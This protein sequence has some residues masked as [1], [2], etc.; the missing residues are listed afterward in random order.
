MEEIIRPFIEYFTTQ[1]Y[2]ENDIAVG[3]I[4]FSG[5]GFLYKFGLKW[6][7]LVWSRIV[8]ILTYN[9][10]IEQSDKIYT[11]FSRKIQEEY[12]HKLRNVEA[13]LVENVGTNDYDD[14]LDAK[15]NAKLRYNHLSDYF[16]LWYKG[17][18]IRIT[19]TREKLEHADSFANT[20]MGRFQLTGI[21][22]RKINQFLADSSQYETAKIE[23]LIKTFTPS[24]NN[25]E[26][27]YSPVGKTFEHL[28]FPEK[29]ELLEKLDKFQS[30][31]S[32]YKERGIEWYLGI[33]LYGKAGSGKSSI[34]KA[35][36]DYTSRD[37]Y[38]V[39]LATT[40]D[41]DF[42]SKF[43]KLGKNAILLLDD[44]DISLATRNKGVDKD[45][46]TTG[47]SLATLLGCLDGPTSRGDL[48]V[49]MTT[50]YKEKLDYALI[51]KG[52]I[53][54]DLE[55]SYPDDQNIRKYL[56]NFY[57]SDYQ[58]IIDPPELSPMVNYQAVCLNNETLEEALVELK[59]EDLI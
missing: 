48:I 22:K 34:A 32:W 19:K 5:F 11:L 12:S 25:W 4:I 2:L 18:I 57:K 30:L 37:L 17:T 20:Y 36:S 6:V 8:R 56:N 40:S 46:T 50:N 59:Q 49:I 7:S 14:E 28:F 23:G 10:T 27:R 24:Y 16:Y 29:Q 47:V 35:V 43:N 55:I 53:D 45:K 51:R 9:L 44:V 58:G 52:R 13:Y 15:K 21:N 3:A 54:V 39:N 42:R 41:S 33:L 38:I 26:E 1:Q 31:Q